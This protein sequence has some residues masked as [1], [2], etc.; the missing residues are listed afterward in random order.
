MCGITC[1]GPG[2][3][4]NHINFLHAYCTS[5]S[6][7]YCSDINTYS[8]ADVLQLNKYHNDLSL[9]SCLPSLLSCSEFR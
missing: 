3:L 5:L 7:P 8:T 6:D 2:A 1:P 4:S 9:A